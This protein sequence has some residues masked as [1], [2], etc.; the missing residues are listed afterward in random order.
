[1]A[2]PLQNLQAMAAGGGLAQQ[3]PMAPTQTQQ[4]QQL[5]TTK[6]TGRA[7]GPTAAP[8]ATNIQEQMAIQN[9]RLQQQ[10]LQRAGT[11]AA[12][13]MG[14][15]AAEAE[16]QYQQSVTELD[17]KQISAQEQYQR[18]V[19]A[20]MRDVAR[21]TRQIDFEKDQAKAEQI[22][23]QLRLSN[24][25]YM[26]NLRMEGAR[27]RL[28]SEANFKEQLARAVFAEEEALLR[29]D[30]SFRAL[31]S[32]DER[33]FLRRLSEI[34]IENALALANSQ[35]QEDNAKAMWG[36]IES[37][38][39]GGIQAAAVTSGPSEMSKS[40]FQSLD[41]SNVEA[42]QIESLGYGRGTAPSVIG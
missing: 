26:N 41:R 25:K 22:G 4:A 5:L 7:A 16:Q 34:D 12:N 17:E 24:D 6:A 13:Q 21:G 2:T 9:T 3:Q 19:E 37:I 11:E 39:K 27:S 29:S 28:I 33:E 20:V 15:E 8:K 31:M 18:E 14:L 40:E 38:I 10:E 23:F 36:G 1:M 35:A 32:A 42:E 30:L